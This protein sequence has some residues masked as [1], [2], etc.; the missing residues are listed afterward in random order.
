MDARR[1]C[2]DTHWPSLTH[3]PSTQTVRSS[4][5]SSPRPNPGACSWPSWGPPRPSSPW[6]RCGHTS[7]W[8]SDTSPCLALPC[9]FLPINTLAPPS[10]PLG[11]PAPFFPRT[12]DTPTHRQHPLPLPGLHRHR[13]LQPAPLPLALLPHGAVV[14]SL[15]TQTQGNV[16]TH[17]DDA[18]ARAEPPCSP[19]RGKKHRH[20]CPP[21]KGWV[22]TYT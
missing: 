10:L 22:S 4:A 21:Q 12:H 1:I 9:V 18:H 16:Y 5:P 3:T 20:A 17:I 14:H 15:F 6:S 13:A 7:P 11:L 19:T 8:V 2:R